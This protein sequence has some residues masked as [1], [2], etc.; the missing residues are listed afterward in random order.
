[1]PGRS[2]ASAAR[3]AAAASLHHTNIVPVFEVGEQDGIV[4]YAMQFIEGQGLDA[5]IAARR[6]RRNGTSSPCGDGKNAMDCAACLK[7]CPDDGPG[8]GPR[9]PSPEPEPEPLTVE[10][11]M[12]RRESDGVVTEPIEALA[13]AIDGALRPHRRRAARGGLDPRPAQT[14]QHI[15]GLSY[16]RCVA[17]IGEQVASALAYAHER[18]VVHRDIKPSNL[19]FD[20]TGVVWVSDFG[21][22]WGEIGRLSHT[23]DMLGTLRYMPPERFQGACD[24]RTDVYGLGLTLYELTTLRRGTSRPIRMR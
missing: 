22:A 10:L 9:D 13:R 15:Q 8:S 2:R 21:L 20:R 16:Y 1:M 14:S 3:R 4:Y 12:C 24:A 11:P 6:Q 5:L 23:G 19:L 7:L 18:G 17:C